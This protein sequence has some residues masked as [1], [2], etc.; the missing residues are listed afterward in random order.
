MI[1]D[2]GHPDTDLAP[3]IEPKSLTFAQSVQCLPGIGRIHRS[4]SEPPPNTN[5]LMRGRDE[6]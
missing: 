5:N 4:E 1:S 6:F 3:G 2:L